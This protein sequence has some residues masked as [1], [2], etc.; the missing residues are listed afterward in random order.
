L[1]TESKHP[2]LSSTAVVA[3]WSSTPQRTPT[4]SAS[5]VSPAA[6]AEG[7]ISTKGE[8]QEGRNRRVLHDVPSHRPSLAR[9]MFPRAAKM[10]ESM[11]L[12]HWEER[13]GARG[14]TPQPP[15]RVSDIKKNK[16]LAENTN[17]VLLYLSHSIM[18][19]NSK[20]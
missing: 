16:V 13:R 15:C 7:I 12:F 14:T 5:S 4:E 9:S 11:Q 1:P 2:Q 19:G 17:P 6:V 18:W 20:N 10:G 3:R 8:L